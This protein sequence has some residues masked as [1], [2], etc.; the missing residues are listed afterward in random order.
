MTV[1]NIHFIICYPIP[2]I[3]YSRFDTP[4][5]AEMLDI[6]TKKWDLIPN[7]VISS[8]GRNHVYL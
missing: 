7:A 6:D 5:T 1:V 8:L 2:A 4:N 3:R